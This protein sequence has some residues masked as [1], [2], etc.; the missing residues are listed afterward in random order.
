MK[1]IIGL[2]TGFIIG[3]LGTLVLFNIPL[4]SLIEKIRSLI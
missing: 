2:L 3:V 4:I 1:Y